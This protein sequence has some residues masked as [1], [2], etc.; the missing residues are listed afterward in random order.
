LQT[1]PMSPLESLIVLPQL[2]DSSAASSSAFCSIRS[3]SLNIGLP[4]SAASIVLQGPD[5][6]ARRA[7]LTAL[8]T[9]AGPAAATFAIASPVA[10][11]YVSNSP[12]SVG[13]THSLLMKSL[14]SRAFG[15][16][17]VAVFFVAVFVAMR[18]SPGWW[19]ESGPYAPDVEI[20]VGRRGP[21]N[22]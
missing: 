6:R 16:D 12:S 15:L 11:L 1:P 8:S 17:V 20:V 4:R 14:V 19:I 13:A 18:V 2:S 21:V 9:S 10:G 7:A 3:A 5:S 22:P